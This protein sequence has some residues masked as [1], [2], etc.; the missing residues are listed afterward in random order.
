MMGI[1]ML[2]SSKII[3]LVKMYFIALAL[4]FV[5]GTR[6]LRI[7]A[8]FWVGI[9]VEVTQEAGVVPRC[10]RATIGTPF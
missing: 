2:E 7:V 6:G 5:V 10:R 1:C 4:L 9:P 3:N 8:A